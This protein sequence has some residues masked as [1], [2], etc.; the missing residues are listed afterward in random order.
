MLRLWFDDV[1]R[2]DRSLDRSLHV[3]VKT[4]AD[5]CQQCCAK[6]WS[7]LGPNGDDRA[8]KNVA[9]HLPPQ[10][11]ACA[12]ADRPHLAGVDPQLAHDFEAV[13]QAKDDALHHRPHHVSKR[14]PHGEADKCTARQWIAV[15]CALARKVWQKEQPFRAWRSLLGQRDQPIIR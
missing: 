12:S 7:F 9:L 15:W 1:A 13:T 14:V 8:A 2:G 10:R 6:G 5:T 3:G 4:G 11:A